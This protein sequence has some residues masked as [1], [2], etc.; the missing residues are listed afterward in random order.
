[1]SVHPPSS[2]NTFTVVLFT[3]MVAII[4]TVAFR[5]MGEFGLITSCFL[6]GGIGLLAGIVL[7]LLLRQ[8]R[9][10][11]A[12]KPVGRAPRASGDRSGS[13]VPAEG[14]EGEP[15]TTLEAITGGGADAGGVG[16]PATAAARSPLDPAEI[17]VAGAGGP[18]DAVRAADAAQGP[19]AGDASR[20]EGPGDDHGRSPGDRGGDI[21]RPA[22]DR[23]SGGASPASGPTSDRGAPRVSSTAG[24]ER[25]DALIATKPAP[26]T[27]PRDGGGDDLTA[28]RGVGQ[29]LQSKLN[30]LGIH[31]YDQIAGWRPSDVLWIDNNLEGFTGRASRDDWVGQARAL[32]EGR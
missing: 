19:R 31:H 16:R 12:D 25:D 1:M 23:S 26:L 28:I 4:A 5:V 6:G 2:S 14:A 10:R 9:S 13:V 3:L 29:T 11:P 20:R 8:P 32:A 15:N 22:S 30:A 17:P 7:G 18:L 27:G 21:A 24:T